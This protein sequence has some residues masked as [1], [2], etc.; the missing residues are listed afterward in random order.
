MNFNKRPTVIDLFSGLGGF[1][2][3]FKNV[4]YEIL[5]AI[6]NDINVLNTHKLNFPEIPFI[7]DDIT[8]IKNSKI[9]TLIKNKDV[10][11]IIGGPP[12]Q[13]FSMIGKRGKD[14]PRNNLF[15]EMLRIINYF[16]PKYFVLENVKGLLTMNKGEVLKTILNE[17]DKI[18]YKVDYKVLNAGD[19]G[20]PQLRE[21]VIFIG[22]NRNQ[23]NNF[24][25]KTHGDG[26]K[27]KYKTVRSALEKIDKNIDNHIPMNHNKIVSE[28]MKY[29]KPGKKLFSDD[30]PNK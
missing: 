21:R 18:S 25:K 29:I 5:L 8:N 4:G 28:R 11:V 30:L 16:K 26:T 23:D 19:Y 27:L 6:D 7:Y 17:F 24:P 1:H 3:G 9:K 20:V 22:N 13:G 15:R 2:L 12:C 14:D 10:D